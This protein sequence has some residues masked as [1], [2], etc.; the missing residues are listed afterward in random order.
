MGKLS[1]EAIASSV[2]VAKQA[3]KLGSLPDKG[4]NDVGIGHTPSLALT[5]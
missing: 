5:A 3:C 4:G 1:L 2:Q